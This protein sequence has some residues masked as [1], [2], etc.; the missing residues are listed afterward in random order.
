[1]THTLDVEAQATL[2]QNTLTI[3]NSILDNLD[4]YNEV[5]FEVLFN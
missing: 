3:E 4:N 2:H 1:M 5:V